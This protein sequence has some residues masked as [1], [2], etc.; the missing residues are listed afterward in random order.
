MIDEKTKKAYIAKAKLKY[1]RAVFALLN[2]AIALA[3]AE[4]S[5]KKIAKNIKTK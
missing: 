2:A 5:Y 3:K 4:E 1:K